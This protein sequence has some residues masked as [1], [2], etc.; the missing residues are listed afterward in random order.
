MKR[1]SAE[2]EVWIDAEF[3]GEL[4]R[5][6]TQILV[7]H[8]DHHVDRGARHLR[9]KHRPLGH[10]D[11]DALE[12]EG[13]TTETLRVVDHEVKPGVEN[14]MGDGDAWPTIREKVLAAEILVIASPTWLGRPAS[15]AE[16]VLER[17][18]GAADSTGADRRRPS[19]PAAL[20]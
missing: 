7:Q 14:D 19:R 6:G 2:L 5:V 4:Q 20:R 3:I 1:Q 17:M 11:D 9:G 10:H 18:D 12:A 15:V 8:R 16:R 13:V